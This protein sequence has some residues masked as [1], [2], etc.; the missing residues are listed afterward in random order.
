MSRPNTIARSIVVLAALSSLLLAM[1]PGAAASAVPPYTL[2][3][4]AV[5]IAS[6]ALIYVETQYTGYLRRKD[7][8]EALHPSTIIVTQRCSGS[9]VS[10]QGHTVTSKHCVQRANENL[11]DSAGHILVNAMIKDGRLTAEQRDSYIKGLAGVVDF[12]GNRAGTTP[13]VKIFGQLFQGKSGLTT[14]PATT[15]EL[16]RG[17]GTGDVA[18]VKFAQSGMPV[19]EISKGELSTNSPVVLVGFGTTDTSSPVTLVARSK[20]MK[21]L[22]LA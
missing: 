1:V 5:A 12:T 20:T 16:V 18:L 8:G 2:E 15:G 9:V 19:V 4:R 14:E 13:S 6:P 7:T 17:S 21:D 11:R 22:R 3:E 10:E